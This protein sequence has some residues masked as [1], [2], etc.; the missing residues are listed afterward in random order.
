MHLLCLLKILNRLFC[1]TSDVTYYISVLRMADLTI[2][3][4]NYDCVHKKVEDEY[5]FLLVCPYYRDI[6][7]R[8]LKKYYC[9]WLSYNNFIKLLT[10][11]SKK[12]VRFIQI[13]VCCSVKT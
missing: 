10:S 2:F 6:R 11:K 12:T 7:S 4:E 1:L 5:Y 8:F 9:A 13:Y 3:R